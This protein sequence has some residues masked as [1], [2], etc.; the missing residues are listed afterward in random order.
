MEIEF[1]ER[2]FKINEDHQNEL[3]AKDEEMVV[4]KEQHE[5]VLKVKDQ[6]K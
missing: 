5:A 1:E 2:E 3:A 6:E 4:L